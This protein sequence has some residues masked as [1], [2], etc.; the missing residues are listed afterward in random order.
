MEN[1]S[2]VN[3]V[4][5]AVNGWFVRQSLGS[6][7]S[8]GYRQY[9]PNQVFNLRSSV[10]V[11]PRSNMVSGN[12]LMQTDRYRY[13]FP[14]H[15][16]ETN[17]YFFTRWVLSTWQIIE[18][19]SLKFFTSQNSELFSSS[20]IWP[21]SIRK[22]DEDRRRRDLWNWLCYK[23]RPPINFIK[24]FLFVNQRSKRRG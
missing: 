18:I 12:Y 22:P 6:P 19:S 2:P 23:L 20:E 10:N 13:M 17:V 11:C 4:I 5:S 16:N 14:T 8:S 15:V 24:T 3:R 7:S 9:R 1:S 21:W